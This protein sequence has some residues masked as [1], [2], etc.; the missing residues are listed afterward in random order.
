MRT[1]TWFD[2]LRSNLQRARQ[3]EARRGQTAQSCLAYS[4]PIL[5]RSNVSFT[6]FRTK[7]YSFNNNATFITGLLF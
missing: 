7:G 5:L 6:C 2:K 3:R 4:A 1:T